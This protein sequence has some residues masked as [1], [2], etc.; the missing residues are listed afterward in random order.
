MA[1]SAQS[2]VDMTRISLRS[3]PLSQQ[4]DI[5][6]VCS[7]CT[8]EV[9]ADARTLLC[10]TCGGPLRVA[11]IAFEPT[12]IVHGDHTLWRY[13]AMLP[14]REDVPVV[15]MGEGL[16]PLVEATFARKKIHFKLEYLSP[17]GSFKD[18]GTTV[19]A[20][21][22]REW[23]VQRASDDS[24]G[25]AGASLAAY[26]ARAGILAEIFVPAHASRQKRAQIEVFGAKLTTV[27][28]PRE[29]ATR[30]L[31]K[32][33]ATSDLV[34]ASHALS[35][36]V[37]EGIK[38]L[39]YEIWEQLGGRAP[40]YFVSPVGQGSLFLGAYR[41]FQELLFG[42]FI[43]KMP[44]M[45]AVQSTA[46]APIVEAVKKGLDHYVPISKCPSIAE[47]I[48]LAEP[49]HDYEILVAIKETGGDAV[50]VSDDEVRESLSELAKVGFY[51]EPTSAVVGAALHKV[52]VN[53][54]VV[55]ALTGSGLK[56]NP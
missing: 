18:R 34:Y 5:N 30:S 8:I 50:A 3:Q 39:A 23:H 48:A 24:S 51:V 20:T 35:P 31:E 56:W 11:R 1:I 55:A 28:G 12:K 22:L 7:R 44:R 53:G 4:S 16:T 32:A 29:M 6:L 43:S 54:V 37:Y 41:G 26:C 25:N 15:T 10:L 42:R 52:D 40:D 49:A 46:C 13:R 14:V 19:L 2:S 45:I 47:G 17:T 38:T 9:R 27:A 33:I 36:F 21:K